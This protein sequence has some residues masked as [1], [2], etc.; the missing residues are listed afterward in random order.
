MIG[1]FGRRSRLTCVL[2]SAVV[3]AASLVLA[4][5]PALAHGPDPMLGTGLWSRDQVVTYQ[6]SAVAVPP[7]WMAAAI[8]AGAGDVAESRDSRAAVFMR[9]AS[10]PASIGYGAYV[11]CDSVGIACM[12]RSGMASGVFGVW[13]RPQGWVFDWGSLRWCQSQSTPTNGCFDAE[14]LA[15]DELGHVEILGHHVNYADASDFADAVVQSGARVRPNTGWN[16]HAFGRCDVARLQLEYER[17]DPSSLV[18]T[19]LALATTTGM[20]PSSTSI[21]VGTT[22]RFGASL[23]IAS[24]TAAESLSGDPISDRSVQLQRRAVGATAWTSMGAMTPSP[25][26]EGSY[27]L[28]WSPTATYD[29]RAVF[30]TPTNE[31]VLGSSS[32][33]VRVSVSGCTG[34]GCPQAVT[35]GTGRLAGR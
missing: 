34:T 5:A 31:G 10:A 20:S 14:N 1:S 25:D 18:S 6:W 9:T 16:Q 23:R 17:R 7:A 12:D 2:R 27:A 29:W 15:L 24:S 30:S 32:A 3:A 21:Y 19:C 4:S 11:P 35:N 28:T 13:F 22:V 26:V 8:D 33:I